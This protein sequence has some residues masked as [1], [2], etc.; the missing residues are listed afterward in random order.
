MVGG[1]LLGASAFVFVWF[2]HHLRQWLQPE[3]TRAATLAN[4]MFSSGLVFV[5]LLLFGTAALVTVP[6]TLAFGDLFDTDQVFGVG[7]SVLPQ[8]GYV[9]LALFALWAAA[10]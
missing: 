2:L 5:V 6:I 4:M 9:V 7:Q 3:A 10:V 1:G 8:L